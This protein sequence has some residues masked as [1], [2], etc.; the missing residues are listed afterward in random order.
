[1]QC[2]EEI[3]LKDNKDKKNI[4]NEKINNIANSIYNDSK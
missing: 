3:S 2:E 4:L 1:M